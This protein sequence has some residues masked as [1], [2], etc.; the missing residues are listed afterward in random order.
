MN[1]VLELWRLLGLQGWLSQGHRHTAVTLAAVLGACSGHTLPQFPLL[2]CH[3][4]GRGETSHPLPAWAGLE[5]TLVSPVCSQG[6]SPHFWSSQALWRSLLLSQHQWWRSGKLQSLLTPWVMCVKERAGSAALQ[7][8]KMLAALNQ[9]QNV[10]KFPN[11]KK[12]G[13][14]GFILSCQPWVFVPSGEM[15]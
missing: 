13:E 5:V 14:P 4:A 9:M 10:I 15:A 6:S 11:W 8:L 7:K 12:F 3:R 1:P 2:S